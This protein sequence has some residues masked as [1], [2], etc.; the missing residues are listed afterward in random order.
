MERGK[1]SDVKVERSEAREKTKL[2]AD[3]SVG[4]R[5]QTNAGGNECFMEPRGCF[6]PGWT[7]TIR[8]EA[9]RVRVCV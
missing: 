1:E 7:G 5:E 9:I 6:L 2:P 4:T 8:E 3:A